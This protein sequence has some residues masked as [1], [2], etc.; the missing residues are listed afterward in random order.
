MASNVRTFLPFNGGKMNH[1]FTPG[2]GSYEDSFFSEA[3]KRCFEDLESIATLKVHGECCILVRQPVAPPSS[4]DTFGGVRS[5]AVTVADKDSNE[6]D[7]RPSDE[8]SV[9]YEWIFCTRLDTRG[10]PFPEN[11][12]PVP[13][14]QQTTTSETE[15]TMIQPANFEKHTYCFIPLEKDYVVGR[16]GK[17]TRPGPD[18]YAA[19]DA[20]VK[21]GALPHPNS[22]D[23]PDYVTVEWIG[24]KHQGNMDCLDV[25]HAITVHGSTIVDVP[26]RTRSAV[27]QMARDVSIEGVVFHDQKT[28][29][30]FKL[31]FDMLVPSCL[32]AQNS[33]QKVS[34]PEFTSIKPIVIKANNVDS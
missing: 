9:Q 13:S 12:I 3:A 32:F 23:A 33:K 6:T 26:V 8:G 10:R 24:K 22:D 20:G 16:G 11:H 28:G 17:K 25:D 18:T 5:N 34:R 29:E 7:A 31:R 27:E 19:I 4:S 30:R 15:K 21:S 2:K 1:V 14:Q